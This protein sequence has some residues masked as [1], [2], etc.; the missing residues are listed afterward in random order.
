MSKNMKK[1][2]EKYSY[3]INEINYRLRNLEEGR[4]L[5]LYGT[6]MDGYLNT[7]IIKLRKELN[8]LFSKVVNG[9]D[10]VN[11]ELNDLF[12]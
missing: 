5:D 6:N 3:E 12:K 9:T 2:K 10:S 8:E 1:V 7:N 11:D 4:V